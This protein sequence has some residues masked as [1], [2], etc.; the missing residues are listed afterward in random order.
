MVSIVFFK[1]QLYAQVGE[2]KCE[3]ERREKASL[4][5]KNR[6][7]GSETH[8]QLPRAKQ[9]ELEEKIKQLEIEKGQLYAH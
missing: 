5:Q 1:S 6:R 9:S 8:L 4:D 3:E 7:K 2:L